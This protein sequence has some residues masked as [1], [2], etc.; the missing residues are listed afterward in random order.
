MSEG[1]QSLENGLVQQDGQPQHLLS[2]TRPG[3]LWAKA[4]LATGTLQSGGGDS[5][6]A[7]TL[8]HVLQV[9]LMLPIQAL[10]STQMYLPGSGLLNTLVLSCCPGLFRP[11]F[12]AR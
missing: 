7:N 6:E 8:T 5:S 1:V 3:A 10:Y 9:S 4:G 2:T 11:A 12:W